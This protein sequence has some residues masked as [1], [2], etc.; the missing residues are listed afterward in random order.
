MF[1]IKKADQEFLELLCSF[2]ERT[3]RIAYEAQND[4]THF[5][6]YCREAFT[7]QRFFEEWSQPESAFWLV[8]HGD[9]LAAYLKLN[10]DNHSELLE[11]NRTVQ[12]ERIYV[13]PEFQGQGLGSDLLAFS[14]EEGRQANCEWIWLSVWQK[15]PQAI[16]FYEQ[17][18][19]N[20][21]G[22]EIFQ[23]GNDPQLDW[24][25]KKRL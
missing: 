20:I 25:M 16:Q 4:P 11:S 18:G 3:F 14:E 10:F 23:V 8:W 1:L 15:N 21:C 13:A 19:Y 7:P 2:A 12:I 6:A 24:V 9:T 5:E 17:N 22:T